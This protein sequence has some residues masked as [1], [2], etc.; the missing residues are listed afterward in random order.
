MITL[1]LNK[2]HEFKVD[3]VLHLRVTSIF[4]MAP[5]KWR[6]Q[7]DDITPLPGAEIG[8]GCH[9]CGIVEAA[10]PDGSLP[11]GWTKRDFEDGH[12]FLCDKDKEAQVCRYCGCTN[13]QACETGNGPCHWVE[14][15]LCSACAEKK[16]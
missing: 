16:Q 12:F 2:A 15:D 6:L 4:E 1:T 8:Y 11:E 10:K 9:V 13:E 3:E 5:G 7:C 14:P